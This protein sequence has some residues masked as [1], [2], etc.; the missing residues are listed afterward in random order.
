MT[1]LVHGK[2][3]VILF[4]VDMYDVSIASNTVL[5]ARDK[6]EHDLHINV[7]KVGVVHVKHVSQ[8]KLRLTCIP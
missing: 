3:K 1:Q 2:R 5:R 7:C 4:I 8:S 6:V